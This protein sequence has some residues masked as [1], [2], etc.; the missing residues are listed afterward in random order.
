MSKGVSVRLP[1]RVAGELE[2]LAASTERA[3]SYI[4][5]KAIETYLLDHADY[6]IALN[7]LRDKDDAIISGSELRKRLGL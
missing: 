4:I 5:R 1:D 2:K 6:Q 7:R 3:K